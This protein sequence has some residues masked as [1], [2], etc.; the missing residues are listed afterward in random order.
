MALLYGYG[1][2]SSVESFRYDQVADLLN[3]I[4]NNTTNLVKAKDVRDSVF[5]LWE[6][7]NDLSVIVA[8]ASATPT[9]FM[10][11]NPTTITV[12][13]VSSGTT[14]PT[15]QTVQQ[16]FNAILYPYT[17][18]IISLTPNTIKEY[19]QS[20]THNLTW[21]VTKRSNPILSVVVN[22]FTI[23]TILPNQL[24]QTGTRNVSGTYSSI[25][26][27]FPVS[28]TNNFLMTVNDGTTNTTTSAT[29]TWM[30]RI[31]WGTIDLSGLAF[32]NPNLTL[33]PSYATFVTSAI[34][35]NLIKAL[36]GAGVGT[37]SELSITKNKT[38]NQ[39]NA[40][41]K[42]LIFAWPSSV[43][44]ATTPTFTVNGLPNTAFTRV[45]TAWAFT[46][47]FNATTNYEVWV[48]NTAYNS[49]ANIIVS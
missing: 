28:T 40:N 32:P 10:N 34:T 29:L 41:G 48:S 46:N 42:Y 27:S 20:L 33:N 9:T 12:G 17:T 38:Y 18:P 19:G 4:P 25:S 47:Q 30:N 36:N 2:G 43:S 35:S 45:N 1:T 49:A 23:T 26:G 13:G 44:G 11:P 21:S 22:G 6:R 24:F 5:S 8:S 7:I 14:F 37:G 16:M 31:Y 15:P 3:Q 39:I